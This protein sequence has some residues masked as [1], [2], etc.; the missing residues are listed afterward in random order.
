MNLPIH[1]FPARM[2]PELALDALSATSH[3]IKVLDPMSGSGTALHHASVLGHEAHGRDMDPLAVLMAK[4][5]TTPIRIAEIEEAYQETIKVALAVDSDS[6]RLPWIDDDVETKKFVG[7][8]FGA[9]Q[10]KELRCL[11]AVLTNPTEFLPKTVTENS[12]DVLKIA[13]SRIIITK[14]QCASLARDTSHSRPHKV[15]GESDYDV[16]NGFKVSVNQVAR[17]LSG[18]GIK[19]YVNVALGDARKLDFDDDQFDL[20]LTSPPYLNAIDY[21]R[22]HKLGLVWLGHSISELRVIRSTSIGAEKALE[23]GDRGVDAVQRA[24]GDISNLPPR[25]K[26]MIERYAFDLTKSVAEAARV[27]KKNGRA[28]YVVGNSCL[29]GVFVSNSSAVS[30]AARVAELRVIDEVERDLPQNRRYLP[31]NTKS[32]LAQ[33][34]RTETVLTFKKD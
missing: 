25:H 33:R 7:F 19:G 34:M 1:P 8:W 16:F 6:L 11:A 3:P 31:I 32:D 23:N 17:R 14:E 5:W 29:K 28:T 26:A 15:V 21:M 9:K 22:G 10:R 27:L 2:A 24:F 18:M 12:V 4:V 20:I 30:A 13:M